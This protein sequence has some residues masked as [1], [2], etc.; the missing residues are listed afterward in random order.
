MTDGVTV[1][2]FVL[3]SIKQKKTILVGGQR[4]KDRDGETDRGELVCWAGLVKACV[5]VCDVMY[6]YM[7]VRLQCGVCHAAT[8]TV[9][10]GRQ[11][12]ENR[13]AESGEWRMVNIGQSENESMLSSSTH[14]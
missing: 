1:F 10:V 14:C 12:A 6:M 5:C 9:H 4:D 7:A 11:R 13:R 3:F 2:V 8:V